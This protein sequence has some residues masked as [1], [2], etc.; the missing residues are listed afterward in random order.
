MQRSG[1]LLP[2]PLHSSRLQRRGF[3]H[4]RLL[5]DSISEVWRLP[6]SAG[7]MVRL[8]PTVP[9]SG[10][11]VSERRRNLMGAFAVLPGENW[12]DRQCVI[13]DDV[14]TSGFT[15][16]TMAKIVQRYGGRPLGVFV[17]RT[18]IDGGGSGA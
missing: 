11:S 4:A 15:F 7:G 1:V 3:N 8:R 18:E 14:I 5:A 10:L 17:A 13:I 12:L 16:S 9:Q 6:V 2:V